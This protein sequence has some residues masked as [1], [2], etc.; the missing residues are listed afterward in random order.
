MFIYTYLTSM[1]GVYVEDMSRSEDGTVHFGHRGV[2]VHQLSL[3]GSA[4]V[5]VGDVMGS[6]GTSCTHSIWQTEERVTGR[7]FDAAEA[8]EEGF[9]LRAVL[10]SR[11][12]LSSSI[13]LIL[14]LCSW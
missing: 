14:E 7:T 4:L 1:N 12:F 9:A 8:I 11:V 6:S 2:R 10:D 13:V 3:I 5:L